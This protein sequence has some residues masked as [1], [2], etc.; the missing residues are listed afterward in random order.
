MH[1]CKE[2]LASSIKAMMLPEI[3]DNRPACYRWLPETLDCMPELL[4]G[5]LPKICQNAIWRFPETAYYMCFDHH[6][7]LHPRT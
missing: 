2:A 5:D 7:Y 4:E 1:I 6:I 3:S